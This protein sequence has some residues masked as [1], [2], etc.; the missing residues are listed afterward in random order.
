MILDYISGEVVQQE[1]L[2]SELGTDENGTSIYVMDKPFQ[3]RGYFFTSFHA[4]VAGDPYIVIEG[5]ELYRYD[6]LQYLR[7]QLARLRLHNLHLV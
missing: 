4:S 7:I 6:P 5:G 1:T 3:K 2:V